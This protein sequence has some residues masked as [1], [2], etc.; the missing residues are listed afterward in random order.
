MNRDLRR[1]LLQNVAGFG[2]LVGVPG[3]LLGGAF[4]RLNGARAEAD[5]LDASLQSRRQL[6]AAGEAVKAEALADGRLAS[7]LSLWSALCEDEARR[8][9]AV[10]TAAQGADVAILALRDGASRRIEAPVPEGE[11]ARPG[12]A[13]VARSH[14]L[15]TVGNLTQLATFLDEVQVIEGLAGV[16]RLRLQ[17]DSD[18]DPGLLSARFTLTWYGP[19][20]DSSTAEDQP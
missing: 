7:D 4:V 13:L 2:L 10:S 16:E 8:I 9:T 11:E 3:L 20:R 17:A 19:E 1:S 18:L 15:D 5:E 12:R 6:H 14:E